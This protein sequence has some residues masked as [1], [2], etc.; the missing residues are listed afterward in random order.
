MTRIY[1]ILVGKLYLNY[2]S[3]LYIKNIR[4]NCYEDFTK[5]SL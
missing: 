4:A 2:S 1:Y 5:Y 3:T